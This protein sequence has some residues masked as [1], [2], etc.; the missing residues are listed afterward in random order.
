MNGWLIQSHF[1]NVIFKLLFVTVAVAGVSIVHEN[2]LEGT[3]AT[4]HCDIATFRDDELR[5]SSYLWKKGITDKNFGTRILYY[6]PLTNV[7]Q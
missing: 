3:N 7:H 6:N 5:T 1:C 2:F 4:L